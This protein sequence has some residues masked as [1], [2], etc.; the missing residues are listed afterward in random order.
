[1]VAQQTQK[2]PDAMI[3]CGSG[4][5]AFPGNAAMM[6]YMRTHIKYPVE[7]QQNGVQGRYL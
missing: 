4:R 6:E 7:A 3:F 5:T 1:M 2:A